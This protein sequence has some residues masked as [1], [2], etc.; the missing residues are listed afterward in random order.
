M[1]GSNGSNEASEKVLIV[2]DE[3][4]IAEGI[5]FNLD[6]LGY[7]TKIADDGVKAILEWKNFS[8]DLVVL[9]LM[10]PRLDGYTVIES[11]RNEDEW[12]PILVL[13]AKSGVDDRVKTLRNGVDDYLLKPFEVDELML[14]INRLLKRAKKQT[15]ERLVKAEKLNR[16]IKTS[17]SHD[18]DGYTFGSN[19]INFSTFEAF[20]SDKKIVLTEQEIKL[21]EIFIKNEGLVLT[22][23]IILQNGWGVNNK[24]VTQRTIDNFIVR[25][26]KYFEEDAKNPKHFISIRS[27]GYRFCK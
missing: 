23:Q 15:S 20:C 27:V 26:R 24:H 3:M 7:Q 17:I 14:R 16:T 8:P 10:L 9:D 25:F 21:L 18:L 5:K 11:I 4:H 2:E 13:S 19:K 22:R 6:A 1:N 12:L